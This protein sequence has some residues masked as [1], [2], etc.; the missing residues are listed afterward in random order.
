MPESIYDLLVRHEGLKLKPY[1]CTAGKLTIGVG[2]NLDDKGISEGEARIMLHNDV[3]SVTAH[4]T[5]KYEWY[6]NLSLERKKVVQSMVFQLGE[7]GFSKFKKLHAAIAG[8]RWLEAAE[9][10][11]ESAWAKQTP[12][13]A[14]ELARMMENG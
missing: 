7:G 8:K 14:K 9:Q 2:R 4:L 13:R 3:D 5:S 12:A 10:M 11:L 6:E 1:Q